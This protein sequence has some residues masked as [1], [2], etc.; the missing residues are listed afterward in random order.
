MAFTDEEENRIQLVESTI[1]QLITWLSNVPSRKQ[2]RQMMVNREQT[3]SNLE[4]RVTTIESQLAQI[5]A[6]LDAFLITNS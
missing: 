5:I 3:I 6:R 2:W 1:N 4:L